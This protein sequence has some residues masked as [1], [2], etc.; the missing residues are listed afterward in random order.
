[1]LFDT[2]LFG[3]KDTL[4][5]KTGGKVA[6]RVDSVGKKAIFYKAPTGAEQYSESKSQIDFIKYESHGIYI[7][8]PPE[9]QKK[10]DSINKSLI[11]IYAGYSLPLSMNTP[12]YR[13]Q[14][15]INFS[16]GTNYGALVLY[17]IPHSN[18]GLAAKFN[19]DYNG[20]NSTE[21]FP[22]GYLSNG[23]SSSGSFSLQNENS[24][25]FK[26]YSVLTGGFWGITTSRVTFITKFLAGCSNFQSP[27]IQYSGE[28]NLQGDFSSSSTLE[29]YEFMPKNSWMFTLDLGATLNIRIIKRFY[30]F[31]NVDFLLYEGWV[32]TTEIETTTY[33]TISSLGPGNKDITTTTYNPSTQISPYTYHA[34]VANLDGS[35]GIGY[36]LSK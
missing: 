29:F 2:L 22:D 6:V 24:P 21:F 4:I 34:P 19:Y 23:F 26:V 35:I 1:M 9:A 27:D 32:N 16:S 20:L 30:G 8:N 11:C 31:L 28:Y 33:S 14:Y 13:S 36:S 7:V 18:F 15:F 12:N 10:K 25:Y 5:Y 3:Q 17:A